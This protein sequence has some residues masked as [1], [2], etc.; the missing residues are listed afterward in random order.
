MRS[1]GEGYSQG[2]DIIAICNRKVDS[3]SVQ[4]KQNRFMLKEEF[5]LLINIRAAKLA[6]GKLSRLLELQGVG[7][8]NITAK[9]LCSDSLVPLKE[10]NQ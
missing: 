5:N 6:E 4:S 3:K 2:E 1:L 9:K 10:R 8:R 7:K